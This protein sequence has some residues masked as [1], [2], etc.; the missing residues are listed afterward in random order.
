MVQPGARGPIQGKDKGRVKTFFRQN[1][2]SLNV[3]EIQNDKA[4]KHAN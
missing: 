3:T 2:K 1:G 4:G